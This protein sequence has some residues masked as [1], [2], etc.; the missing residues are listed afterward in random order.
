MQ[1]DGGFMVG[2]YVTLNCEHGYNL[3]GQHTLKC[4]GDRWDAPFPQCQKVQCGS[5]KLRKESC[6]KESPSLM[7]IN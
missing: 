6:M 2:S 5:P 3:I 1:A 7:E 4:K